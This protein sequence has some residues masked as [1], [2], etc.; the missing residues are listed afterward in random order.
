MNTTT[1]TIKQYVGLIKRTKAKRN[2]CILLAKIADKIYED[3]EPYNN[4]AF[5]DSIIA[6]VTKSVKGFI[7]NENRYYPKKYT[8]SVECK[9]CSSEL[10]IAFFSINLTDT[11]NM[12]MTTLNFKLYSVELGRFGNVFN[13][14]ETK[15][16]SDVYPVLAKERMDLTNEIK[17]LRT[18]LK[19]LTNVEF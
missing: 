10:P 1:S 4:T 14:A 11:K 15:Y 6:A 17:R 13:L 12:I 8:V 9:V 18:E 16:L 3:L 2:N 7:E 5:C 19:T